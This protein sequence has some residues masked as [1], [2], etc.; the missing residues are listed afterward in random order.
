MPDS[1]NNFFQSQ[2]KKY[3]RMGFAICM[4]FFLA[5]FISATLINI[6]GAITATGTVVQIGENK[7]VQHSKGG[8]LKEI[9]VEEGD[10]VNKGDT[11]II[12]DSVSLDSKLTLLKQQEFELRLT[13]DRLT[14]M[15]ANKEEFIIDREKYAD[16]LNTYPIAVETQLSLFNAQRNLVLTNLDELNVRLTGLQDEIKAL[17]KQRKTS[18]QQLSILDESINELTALY[19]RQLISKSRLTTLERDRVTVLT[20][21][22]SL[23][24][25][26]LQK[27]NAYNETTQRIE[28]L[29][30]EHKE[31]VWKEI[32]KAKEDLA[33][34]KNEIPSTQDDFKRLEIKAPVSGRVHKLI[35]NNINEVIKP[36]EAILEIVPNSGNFIVHAQVKPQDI[37]QISFGQETRIRFDSFNQ[38]STPEI[39]GRVI[40]IAADSISDETAK[41]KK[42]FLVKVSLEPAEL[43]KA[44]ITTLNSGLPVSTMFTTTE[45]SLIN[46]LIKPL[47]DQL[48]SAFRET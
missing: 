10:N 6:S 16:D 39:I 13:I 5:I 29:N 7:S 11:I 22:E 21:L 32:E 45:R 3:T 24:V 8:P 34:I 48:F 12:L 35:V 9:L 47:K 4:I 37:E 43:A 20:Q 46:Y 31:K 40:F 25:S 19:E 27:Q 33:K 2:Y 1:Q 38:Q 42:H 44:S 26:T 15:E 17:T 14:A 28:K 36:G 41:D 30:K 23:K 18:Q